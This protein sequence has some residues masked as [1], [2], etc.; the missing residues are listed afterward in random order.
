MLNRGFR[1]EFGLELS[2]HTG[3]NS[4][5]VIAGDASTAQR[6][7]TGD[8]VNTAAR[9]EQTAGSGDVVLG[10]LTY[11]L[12][13]DQIEVEFMEPLVLKGKAEPVPAYRLVRVSAAAAAVEASTSGT[14]FVGRE[15]EMGRLSGSLDEAITTHKA[16]LVTVVG[17]AG[18]GKSRLIREFASRA[19]GRRASSV[20]A[21]CRTATASRSGRWPRSSARRPASATRTHRGSRRGA[22]TSCSRRAA[23]RT[24]R[25]SWSGSPR[26]INLSAASSRAELIWGVGGCSRRSPPSAR[27]S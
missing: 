11:R 17:D 16:R 25:P 20:A 15:A 12:A 2:N 4:G 5:E 6:M 22:S 3:V 26:R 7:V 14:P 18:V 10:D 19:L 24:G 9:L 8:A 21:A 13:R 23:P 27:S 1:T